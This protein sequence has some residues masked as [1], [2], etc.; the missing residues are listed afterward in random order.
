MSASEAASEALHSIGS[1]FGTSTDASACVSELIELT[2]IASSSV[3]GGG[4]GEAV[5][6]GGG[7][8]GL[9]TP[10]LA[11]G[12]TEQVGMGHV[13]KSV[14]TFN[15]TW[16]DLC[17]DL[18]WGLY[19]TG[20]SRCV[21]CHLTCHLKCQAK[22]KLNCAAAAAAAA[23]SASNNTSSTSVTASAA[24]AVS[25]SSALQRTSLDPPL[26]LADELVIL[27]DSSSSSSS[28]STSSAD[29]LDKDESTLANISTLRDEEPRHN[30][31]TTSILNPGELTR[32]FASSRGYN[33]E[34]SECEDDD[35]NRT[36][37]DVS[38][39]EDLTLDEGIDDDLIDDAADPMTSL[40]PPQDMERAILCY[41]K[42][43]PLGQETVAVVSELEP[44]PPSSQTPPSDSNILPV[45]NCRGYIR[46]SL[47]LRRPIHVAAGT[48]PPSIYNL[49]SSTLTSGAAA[50]G[51]RALTS[52]YLPH[53]TV[54]ALHLTSLTCVHDV[55]RALLSKF[56]VVD[57]PHKYALYEKNSAGSGSISRRGSTTLMAATEG[58]RDAPPSAAADP[59]VKKQDHHPM[60]RH[61]LRKMSGE[62]R[63][64]LLALARC[65]DEDGEEKSST[66]MTSSDQ[67]HHEECCYF[68]LQENDPGEICWDSFTVPELKNFLLILDREEAW[69]KRRIHEKYELVQKTMHALMDQKKL[70]EE[71]SKI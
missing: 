6:G 47:N 22:I 5:V 51:E 63:P 42:H 15:P 58:A 65:L 7:R 25:F 64:L 54:R 57:N 16:C 50:I 66:T 21:F 23:T 49:T 9:S 61:N 46:V 62:E 38:T 31:S 32:T 56:R 18:V 29:E 48:R 19:D 40:A 69:Y 2:N 70:E 11:E 4:G 37:R 20:A 30:S 3:V 13:F 52:F 55:I 60:G 71:S 12:D 1:K 35:L 28:S 17:R 41:N 68:V 43:Y 33:I 26:L 53:G 45:T 34:E 59:R 10:V 39:Y 8:S 67:Q 14:G 27:S 24:A 44:P 36:L